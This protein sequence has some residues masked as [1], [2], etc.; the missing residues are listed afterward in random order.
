MSAPHAT[1]RLEGKGDKEKG[2]RAGTGGR[3]RMGGEGDGGSVGEREDGKR[4]R[5]RQRERDVV[6]PGPPP[7]PFV[8]NGAGHNFSR[9]LQTK[10]LCRPVSPEW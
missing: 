4:G 1:R 6:G 9:M 2:G 3:R 10:G 7:P 8:E 5:G